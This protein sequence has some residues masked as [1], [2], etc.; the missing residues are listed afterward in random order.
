M[1]TSIQD[2]RYA[3]RMLARAP[4]FS[5]VIILT[6]G[7]GIGANTA[8]F[9]LMDQVLLRSLTVH[10]PAALVQLDGPGPFSGRTL[11]D[12]TFSYP[13]YRDLRDGNTVFSGLVAQF[14]TPVTLS[15]R[16]RSE[17]VNAELVSG[18]TFDVLGVAPFLGRALTPDDDRV[19]GGHPVVLV[20][21]GYWQRRFAGDPGVIGQAVTINSTPM[22][23]VGVA[24]PGFAGVM[25]TTAGDVFVPLMMK[26]QV[27]PTLNDLMDRRSRFVKVVGRLRPGVTA[28]AAKAELDV[29]YRQVNEGELRDTF[30]D[31]T[32]SFSTR[33][34]EKTLV[35]HPAAR[36]LSDAR[37]DFSTPLV[38][39]MAMVGLV[40]LIACANVAN[41]L[42][43]RAT[44]RQKE[45]AVRLALGAPRGRLIRQTLTEGFVLAGAGA[46]VGVLLS[47][48]LGDLLLSLLPSDSLSRSLVTTPDLR[49]GLFTLAIAL[50]T[51][52]GFGLAPALQSASVELNKTMRE[53]GAA[54]G[55]GIRQA[56]VRKG[57]V[58]AQVTLSMLLVAGG[59]LFARSLYNLQHLNRGFDSGGLL[60]FS[61]EPSLSGYDQ[62]RVR[63]FADRLLDD[64]RRLPG[65]TSASLAEVAALTNNASRRTIEVQGYT[66]A[67]RENMNA[68]ANKVAPDYFRTMRMPLLAGREFTERDSAGAPLVAV[69]NEA[70]ARRFFG[71]ESAVGRRF[72]WSAID[73]PGAIEIVGVVQDAFYSSVRQGA[74][75]PDETPIFAYA[76]FAQGERLS[77][78][79]VYVRSA[80][81]ALT[82]LPDELRRTVRQA[83]PSMPVYG[84]QAVDTTVEQSLFTERMLALLSAAFGLVATLLAAIGLYG[85]MA[86]TVSRRTREIGI[87]IALGANRQTVLWLVLREVAFITI[88][89]IALAI[90]AVL[91]L[92][93]VVRSQLFGVSAADPW[94]LALAS[95][96][97]AV[98]ALVAGWLPARR[99]ARVQ[100]LLALR[101]E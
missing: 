94:T 3:L 30:T 47:I 40:L 32:E 1:S 75:G 9:S 44:T 11:D 27:T 46:L 90:P 85:V 96:V 38:M 63:Q 43:T 83:D 50:L 99:A 71:T 66:P 41:L 33:F 56:R 57:L 2:L 73:N 53:V 76:P 61:V 18:N 58:M 68:L 92:G 69:V 42:L 54:T 31:A 24:P 84:L 62:A 82:A 39:L 22:T 64:V 93:G 35:L 28:T 29:L 14:G 59:G 4:G 25:S 67:A 10:D 5:T 89:G 95:S 77:E 6:L 86:Y 26:A 72:G 52:I 65:V 23:I 19:P 100:P 80:S 91:A 8:I 98:V 60:S 78:M 7:L 15:L 55:G 17:R 97:L 88:A 34:R 16:D 87:R 12:R 70:F 36:G 37:E 49:V 101:A 13:M 48:W 21:Y 74:R 81:D 45:M 20:G 51:A 79:T